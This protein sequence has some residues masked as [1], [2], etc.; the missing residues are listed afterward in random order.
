MYNDGKVAPVVLKSRQAN[1]SR[2]LMSNSEISGES[3][4]G[5][6][7]DMSDAEKIVLGRRV[8]QRFTGKAE[9]IYQ[10]RN[11]LYGWGFLSV[12]I[13]LLLLDFLN[14]ILPLWLSIFI[15]LLPLFLLLGI[16]KLHKYL[17][18]F[19]GASHDAEEEG[20]NFLRS[21][22]EAERVLSLI[23]I[24][25]LFPELV[26]ARFVLELE[27]AITLA[28]SQ[29]N[30]DNVPEMKESHLELLARTLLANHQLLGSWNVYSPSAEYRIAIMRANR[31][32]RSETINESIKSLVTRSE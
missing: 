14:T 3:Q 24:P 15:G 2:T 6:Y 12:I 21:E 32:L 5:R 31:Y 19:F 18:H 27:N 17:N 23:A 9:R 25:E 29:M 28:A 20:E 10:L 26:Q 30:A 11:Q 13:P 22:K 1:H 16:A 4:Y 7:A 8:V